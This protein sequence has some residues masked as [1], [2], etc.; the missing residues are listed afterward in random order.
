M[1][2]FACRTIEL[3]IAMY[4]ER[5]ERVLSTERGLHLTFS[6]GNTEES[7]EFSQEAADQILQA[8]QVVTQ[9]R[10]AKSR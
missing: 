7:I 3:R 1:S 10:P 2:Y 4:L 9:E 8:L 6:S 5:L